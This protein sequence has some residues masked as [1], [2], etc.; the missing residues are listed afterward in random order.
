MNW[1]G[2]I[3]I[4]GIG[5]GGLEIGGIGIGGIGIASYYSNSVAHGP[6]L[7]KSSTIIVPFN[8]SRKRLFLLWKFLGFIEN[9]YG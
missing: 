3:G 2:G 9:I 4:G 6:K 7:F 8:H 5:I 1:I